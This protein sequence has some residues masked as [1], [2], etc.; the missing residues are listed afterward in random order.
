MKNKVCVITGSNSGTG[1]ETALALAKN[2]WQ[3][4]MICRNLVRGK[5]HKTKLLIRVKIKILI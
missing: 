1:Y 2:D 4:T 3:V 5:M